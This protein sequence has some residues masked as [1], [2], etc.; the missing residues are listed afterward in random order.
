MQNCTAKS[1]ECRNFKRRGH[2]EKMCRSLKKIQHIERKSSSAEEDD[3]DYNK[4]QKING[5]NQKVFYN[6]TLL[7]NESP[8][9]FL[10]DS[11][12]PVTLIPNC[13]F[14]KTTEV[15]PIITTYRVVHIHRI[16]FTGQ[17]KHWRKQTTRR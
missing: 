2:Y 5:N 9:Q 3:W 11:G 14:N 8:I 1:A 7:V 13:L 17:T 16:E 15:E 12:S 6:T 10:I 4:I